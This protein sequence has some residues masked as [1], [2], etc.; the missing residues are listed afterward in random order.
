MDPA[1]VATIAAT[2]DPNEMGDIFRARQQREN[3]AQGMQTAHAR[4]GRTSEDVANL[5]RA[6]EE[7][8]L[9]REAGNTVQEPPLYQP[10]AQMA[11]QI[12][13]MRSGGGSKSKTTESTAIDK[14]SADAFD[15]RQK[16]IGERLQAAQQETDARKAAAEIE[17]RGAKEVADIE[18]QH[19]ASMAELGAKKQAALAARN[20]K[21]EEAFNEFKNSK[22]V[23]FWAD[24]SE[25]KRAMAGWAM[26]LGAFGSALNGGPNQAA[27]IINGAID[28]DFERQRAI[29]DKKA[30]AFDMSGK[31]TDR[32]RQRFADETNDL[33]LQ[34]AAKKTAAGERIIADLKARGVNDVE[35]AG[36]KQGLALIDAGL[37]EKQ[38]FFA[39][40]NARTSE[41]VHSQW[42]SQDRIVPG[43][44]EDG[45][46]ASGA[47]SS[48]LVYDAAGRPMIDVGDKKKAADVNDANSTYRSL[49]DT[50]AKL[51]DNF[52]KY[53]TV[54]VLNRT[55]KDER[56]SL[57]GFARGLLN[58]QLKFGAL[59]KGAVEQLG[60]MLEPGTFS[61]GSEKLKTALRVLDDNQASF[62]NSNGIPSAQYM[63]AIQ[64]P[65]AGSAP[66][67]QK[68][69]IDSQPGMI[70]KVHKTAG[71]GW[72]DPKTQMFTP[73]S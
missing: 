5:V 47:G 17:A 36:Y 61:N 42:Q 43:S 2:I 16:L 13:K 24:K 53:G 59:D 70:R 14:A 7:A 51:R 48:S 1:S 15:E 27:E 29:I 41:T 9:V 33:D 28:R 52:E 34:K 26:A 58:R 12:L 54:E 46:S 22:I 37:K 8:R 40:Q 62:L 31:M 19:A 18:T 64:T 45:S 11:A 60:V 50:V 65:E 39:Q 32:E 23:D 66:T 56:E 49:R 71:P 69:D 57:Q 38:D 35:N 10:P 3:L 6:E 21:D 73:D 55:A 72:F 4:M 44:G 20:A 67:A 68:S 63:R 30:A 25:S